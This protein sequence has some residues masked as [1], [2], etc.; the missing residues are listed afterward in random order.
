MRGLRYSG[1]EFENRKANRK[2]ISTDKPQFYRRSWCASRKMR[3]K[4]DPSHC[5]ITVVW[6]LAFALLQLA[7]AQGKL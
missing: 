1:M 6:L 4:V 5:S 2:G 7:I 3:E